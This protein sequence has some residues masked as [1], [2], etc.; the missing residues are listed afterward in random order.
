MSRLQLFHDAED[1]RVNSAVM[2]KTFSVDDNGEIVDVI[3]TCPNLG[4]KTADEQTAALPGGK[5]SILTRIWYHP[6]AE[7]V[8]NKPED[9]VPH[10]DNGLV[11][12]ELLRKAVDKL[13][14]QRKDQEK[15]K[16]KGS[17][18][19]G[20]NPE[21]AQDESPRKVSRLRS[22]S[23]SLTAPSNSRARPKEEVPR[24]RPSWPEAQ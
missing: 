21:N 13:K 4:S 22:S 18:E 2:R 17:G 10:N 9:S 19:E 12:T 14:K 20:M 11:L 1:L 8:L 23:S 6:N 7:E 3:E 15:A 5:Q 16:K 24:W